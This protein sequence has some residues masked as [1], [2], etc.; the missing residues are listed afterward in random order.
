MRKTCMKIGEP[1]K[2]VSK[3]D[4]A[5]I[6]SNLISNKSLYDPRVH[7]VPELDYFDMKPECKEQ[8]N[9]IFLGG[10]TQALELFK[11]R[12]EYE[13]EALKRG[14]INPNLNKPVLFTKEI[15]LSPYLRFGC[16]SVRKFYWDLN[17][18]YLKVIQFV[19]FSVFFKNCLN[20]EILST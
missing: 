3:P 7:K 14:E 1:E 11:R 6:A 13:K 18:A 17:K 20:D 10:E 16:L 5:F 4:L 9:C 19:F 15:S 8:E 12:L 2:P